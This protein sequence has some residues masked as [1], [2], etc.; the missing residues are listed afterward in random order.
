M[1][2]T[3]VA[4]LAAELNRSAAALLEQLQSAGVS[5]ASTDDA[6]TESDKERLLDHLRTA[7][8]TVP[9]GERKKIT[10]TRKSTSEIKQADSS[11][12]ARTIQVEVRKKRTFIKRDDAAP[13]AEEPTEPVID[14]QELARRE[15]EAQ[16]QAELLRQQEAD[17]AEKRRLREEQEARDREAAAAVAT[18]AREAAEKLAV[19][20]AAAAAATAAKPKTAEETK[21][22]AAKAAE[23]PA[24]VVAAPA[25]PAKPVLRVIKA[26]DVVDEDKQRAADLA[27][28]RKAAEDEAAA[29]RA[30]MNAPKKV[31][32]AKKPEEVKPA[33]VEIKGTIHKKV[34]AP[35]A[36]GTT[37]A[38]A[39]P[40]DKKAVKSEKLSSSWAD[41]AKKRTALKPGQ[42]A[43]AGGN[44]P[45]WRAPRVGRRGERSDGSQSTFVAPQE[46]QVQEVHV[47]ETISVAD[48]AHKMSVKASEVIKQLMKLGQMVTI[49]QQLDQ[50]TAMIVV[51]EMGHTAL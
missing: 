17:L 46:A 42:R 26:A 4:Q 30:M 21:A 43:P 47:P 37:T 6:L 28:R 24:P 40:G 1:A 33:A 2:T 23:A 48:L 25:E 15:V 18:A 29:I 12:K 20:Q 36:P 11:G 38:V 8:G 35:G 44:R 10:L 45:G 16:A 22:G 50:E 32:V 39:K 49:N 9:G 34:G 14:E 51:E 19:E 41:D 31:L 3:T 5:K 27:K 13:G 7:H